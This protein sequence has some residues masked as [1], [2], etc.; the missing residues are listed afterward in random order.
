MAAAALAALAAPALA[1]RPAPAPPPTP[2][3]QF[4][5]QS[6][7]DAVYFGPGGYLLD[8]QARATLVAQALYFNMSPYLRIRIEGHSDELGTREYALGLGERRAA[9]VRNYLVSLGVEP[10]RITVVSW[11]KERPASGARGP[12]AAALNRRAVVVLE[13]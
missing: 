11:G 4:V 2:Q 7:S 12:A 5:A 3:A 13:P 1:Q 6:G 9:M 8:A 10:S